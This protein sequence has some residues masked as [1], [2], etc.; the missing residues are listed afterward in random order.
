MNR[1]DSEYVSIREAAELCGVSPS[2]VRDHIRKGNIAGSAVR[3]TPTR[4]TIRRSAVF[5][6]AE[7]REN[8]PKA[9]AQ[10]WGI[11]AREML[12]EFNHLAGIIG[13]ELAN[14]HLMKLY[15][16]NEDTIHT[17]QRTQERLKRQREARNAA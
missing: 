10:K 8:L 16:L 1:A 4:V 14:R 15:G 3:K 6:F 2:T 9:R 5:E 12:E 17:M 11:P 13:P 7:W